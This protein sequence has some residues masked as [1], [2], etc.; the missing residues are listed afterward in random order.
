MNK[1]FNYKFITN[2]G[3][4]LT[5][6]FIFYKLFRI[7]Y[8]NHPYILGD[9]LI[10]YYDGGFKRRGLSG[11]FVFFIQDILNIDIQMIVFMIQISFYTLFFIFLFLI[12]K[13]KKFQKRYSFT[14]GH[15]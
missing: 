1:I 4:L 15:H 7:N 12:L 8:Q 3:L 13:E 11:I 2:M 10:N 6:V 5:F 9:W 14:Y